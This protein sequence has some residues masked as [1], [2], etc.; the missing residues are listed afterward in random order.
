M[1]TSASI[2]LA[3]LLYAM[4]ASYVENFQINVFEGP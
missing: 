2:L 1:S 4:A 3:S